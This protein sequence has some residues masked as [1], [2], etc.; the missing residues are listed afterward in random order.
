M[1]DLTNIR[2][3]AS[4]DEGFVKGVLQVFLTKEAEYSEGINRELANK[5]YY[6]LRQ[7]VHKIKSSI[8]VLGMMEFK[9]QLNELELGMEKGLLSEEQI[10]EGSKAAL[11]EFL[12]SLQVVRDY[13][14]TM[15]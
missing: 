6:D 5:N 15:P 11:T 13:L 12:R 8:S 9:K 10:A 14:K 2:E 3:I 7:V 4:G 1:L